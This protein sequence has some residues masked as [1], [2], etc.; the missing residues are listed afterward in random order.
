M[1]LVTSF[2]NTECGL[3][4]DLA[5]K[6]LARYFI[7]PV[8]DRSFHCYSRMEE[9]GCSEFHLLLQHRQKSALGL[10]DLRYSSEKVVLRQHLDH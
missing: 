10:E 5:R 8:G 1:E 6:T 7:A 4:L 2:E 3:H 9:F